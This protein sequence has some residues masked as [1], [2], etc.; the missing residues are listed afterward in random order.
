MTTTKAT[1]T[2]ALAELKLIE[3]KINKK[4]ET[5]LANT[6]QAQHV[7]DPFESE[8]GGQKFIASEMQSLKDL[9][10]RFVKIRAAINKANGETVVTIGDISRTVSE[11]LIYKREVATNEGKFQQELYS[12]TKM[13]LDRAVSNPQ[14]F[15]NTENKPDIVRFNSNVNLADVLKENETTAEALDKLDGQLS[16]KNATVVIEY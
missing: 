12:K 3:K 4:Q 2:E 16:L 8:G 11:W 9:R 7:K 1:I 14:A 6:I 5:I 10:T 15:T 13:M